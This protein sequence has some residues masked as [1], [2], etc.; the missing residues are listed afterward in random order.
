MVDVCHARLY[1]AE[2]AVSCTTSTFGS[3]DTCLCVYRSFKGVNR[4]LLSLNTLQQQCNVMSDP[5][6]I[7]AI[8][9]AESLRNLIGL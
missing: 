2:S 1:Y 8:N 3:T 6:A 9:Q 4:L 5:D 7:K